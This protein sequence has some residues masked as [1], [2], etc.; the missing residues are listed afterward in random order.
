M[1]E[2]RVGTEGYVD[3]FIRCARVK[4]IKLPFYTFLIIYGT[5]WALNMNINFV[6]DYKTIFFK[7]IKMDIKF[8][9]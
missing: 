6:N 1:F 4:Q 9:V 7:S 2:I 3:K 8:D 5:A